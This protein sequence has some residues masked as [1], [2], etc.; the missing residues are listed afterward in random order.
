MKENLVLCRINDQK[1]LSVSI[2]GLVI[3]RVFPPV[4]Y[5]I[6]QIENWGMGVGVV[7]GGISYLSAFSC[8]IVLY[9]A[10]S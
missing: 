10:I 6:K 3:S 1:K 4:L 7:G 9:F 8:L 2:L 5:P